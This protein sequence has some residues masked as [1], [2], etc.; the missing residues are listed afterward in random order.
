MPLTD[1]LHEHH[2]VLYTYN[3]ICIY[4]LE[5]YASDITRFCIP[6]TIYVHTRECLKERNRASV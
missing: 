5:T 3:Y 6:T 4:I 2:K 1:H